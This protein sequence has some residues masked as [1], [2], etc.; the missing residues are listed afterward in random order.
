MLLCCNKV[1]RLSWQWVHE[2][3][4]KVG[5]GGGGGEEGRIFHESCT[6]YHEWSLLFCYSTVA[7]PKSCSSDADDHDSSSSAAAAASL[8]SERRTD[9][10]VHSVLA[11]Y[12][13][14]RRIEKFEDIA[15]AGHSLGGALAAMTHL[16]MNYSLDFARRDGPSEEDPSHDELPGKKGSPELKCF[17]YTEQLFRMALGLPQLVWSSHGDLSQE[18]PEPPQSSSSYSGVSS[19]TPRGGAPGVATGVPQPIDPKRVQ[20]FLFASAPALQLLST[21]IAN[22]KESV[23]KAATV[24]ANRKS[25]LWRYAVGDDARARGSRPPARPLAETRPYHDEEQ[26]P[27]PTH[28]LIFFLFDNDPTPRLT[29]FWPVLNTI[30]FFKSVLFSVLP[31]R[32]SG[33]WSANLFH[34]PVADFLAV[35]SEKEI[36]E[37]FGVGGRALHRAWGR[38]EWDHE[39][40]GNDESGAVAQSRGS[41]SRYK[42]FR[43]V[44]GEEDT[45]EWA[46]GA[47]NPSA[48]KLVMAQ[49]TLFGS[50]HGFDP[51]DHLEAF[52]AILHPLRDFLGIG[53]IDDR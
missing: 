44:G 7:L 23:Q 21:K 45:A 8:P 49:A 35:F 3:W 19:T 20:T 15:I 30:P 51:R 37:S 24:Q 32:W 27:A 9:N 36:A 47:A 31:G 13:R 28:G 1:K 29:G 34:P 43:L 39:D 48:S 33:R 10:Y 4:E 40:G 2:S 17:E 46:L 22:D 41:S 25:L 12:M 6:H 53:R 16:M 52:R 50:E 42:F 14:L 38:G 26:S 5:A 18:E 11:A